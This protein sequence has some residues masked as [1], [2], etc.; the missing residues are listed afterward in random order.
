MPTDPATTLPGLLLSQAA[1]D[2]VAAWLGRGTVP[3][4]VLP[5]GGWTAVVPAGHSQAAPPYDDA[6]SVLAARPVPGPLRTV[7][8]FFVVEDAQKAVVV[9]RP[10]KPRRSQR[11]LAW[12]PE[13]GPMAV[14]TYEPVN[15][16]DL[17]SAAGLADAERRGVLRVLARRDGECR[18][19]LS[20]LVD[21][22]ALPGASLLSGS[23]VPL[24]EDATLVTPDPRRVEKF[25]RDVNERQVSHDDEGSRT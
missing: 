8:G 7:L 4:Y 22:L 20:D 11:W 1:P 17:L 23:R 10:Q 2:K 18:T 9:I 12:V 6:L 3:G 24:Q 14:P 5:L 15:V 19:L 21:A 25:D 13:R 16:R